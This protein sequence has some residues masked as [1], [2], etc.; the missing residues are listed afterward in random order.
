M[1]P[2]ERIRKSVLG[3]SQ[4]Q[5]AAIAGVRQSTVSRWETGELSPS[6]REVGRIVRAAGGKVSADDFL[7]CAGDV[8]EAA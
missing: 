3:L 5:F 7:D 4:A 8:T 2:I 6:I 1:S